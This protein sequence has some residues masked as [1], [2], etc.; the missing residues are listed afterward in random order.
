MRKRLG[1]FFC[2]FYASY[3]IILSVEIKNSL[4]NKYKIEKQKEYQPDF[5]G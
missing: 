5:D 1:A 2:L 3:D 4:K